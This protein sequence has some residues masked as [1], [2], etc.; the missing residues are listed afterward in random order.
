MKERYELSLERIREI[1]V[2]QEGLKDF[3]PYFYVYSGWIIAM[4]DEYERI[5]KEGTIASY[6]LEE[7]KEKN[8]KLYQ[9]IMKDA[10]ENSY[11][12]PQ[13]AVAEFGKEYGRPLC[14][15]AAELRSLIG[16]VY[17]GKLE[18]IVIRMELFLEIFSC[19]KTA[20]EDFDMPPKPEELK[21][22]LYWFVSDY[23]ELSMERKIASQTDWENNFFTRIVM[24]SDLND[25]RYLYQYGEY[26]SKN[27]LKTAS[28]INTLD[29]ETIDLIADAYVT[30][31]IR[32]FEVVKKDLSIKKSV[33]I[34]YFAGFERIVK[35]AIEKFEEKGLKP[36]IYRAGMDIFSRTGV[37]KIGFYGSLANPQY[38]YDHKEDMAYILDGHLVTRKLECLSA[39]FELYRQKAAWLAGPACMEVFGE[40]TFIPKEK[41]EN[42]R[43]DKKQQPLVLEERTKSGAITNKYI[44]REERSFTI[45]AFPIAAIGKDFP[46]IFNEVVK[47][48]TLDTSLYE[49]IQQNIIDALDLAESVKIKGTNGN[50]TDL[51][52]ALQ[53]LSNPQK[54]T[55]FENCVA[56]VNIPAGEVFTTPKL[57][58]TN[59]ILH[60]SRVFL[61]ELEYRNL[62]LTFKDGV[63][64]DYYCDNENGKTFIEENLLFHHKTLPMGEFA[65]GTNTT[66][67]V[68][69][70]KYGI[71][72]LLPILIAEKTG[73]HFA[74]GDSCYSQEEE[75]QVFNSNQKEMIAKE[76]DYSL[77]RKTDPSK[78]YFYCH[79]DITIPY[80]ELGL[81]EGICKDGNK[82][83]IIKD[84]RFTLPGT[85]ELNHA[86]S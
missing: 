40:P 18:E 77:L 73:P 67:Y 46:D 16:F 54:E 28:F 25:L 9:D 13:K 21:D 17:E 71:E 52:V 84:G 43:Y 31:F 38:D 29:E 22:I 74:M 61:N 51:T 45:I 68:M 42:I 23:Y 41:E 64:T 60:V 70:R 26:V 2:N 48:N 69:A 19:F 85:E 82:I 20:F 1:N 30:G 53:E 33:N 58:G 32:G 47:I 56:D 79:T 3:C 59:G 8:D 11:V 57:K 35:R 37:S 76:N 72:A 10:Y 39:A 15:L 7:L 83:C 75:V 63:I 81:I 12:N 44:K 27:D 6:S 65:I 36:V 49:R 34:R 62:M 24:E 78:A 86:F 66:A 80:D 55:K 5:L 4:A 50:K 14:I